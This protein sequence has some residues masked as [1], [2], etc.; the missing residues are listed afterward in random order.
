MQLFKNVC[1]NV[2]KLG[3]R[4]KQAIGRGITSKF[5]HNL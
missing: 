5:K 3:D 2:I 1:R 4:D